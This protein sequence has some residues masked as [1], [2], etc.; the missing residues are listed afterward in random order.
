MKIRC[1]L[2]ALFLA[3]TSAQ[4]ETLTGTPEV[5]DGDTLRMEGETIRLEGID[6]LESR[7]F[8]E[9]AEGLPY[10]CG[11]EATARLKRLIGQDKVKCEGS[12][13]DILG[14][15]IAVCCVL[16]P[17]DKT[18][19]PE[20]TCYQLN[21]QPVKAGHALAQRDFSTRYVSA[22]NEA[23]AAKRGMWAGRFVPPWDWRRGKRLQPLQV[24]ET[25]TLEVVDADALKVLISW[26]D[27]RR[28]AAWAGAAP[29]GARVAATALARSGM[30]DT[31]RVAVLKRLMDM[32][33]TVAELARAADASGSAD[34]WGARPLLDAL[35][36]AGEAAYGANKA[37]VA[38]VNVS[39]ARLDT[40]RSEEERTAIAAEVASAIAAA[41]Q[42]TGEAGEAAYAAAVSAWGAQAGNDA[43]YAAYGDT[44][45]A[46]GQV[47][48]ASRAARQEAACTA[49]AA[50]MAAIVAAGGVVPEGWSLA[51]CYQLAER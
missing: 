35:E 37:N 14:R 38:K 47:M 2:L 15:L 24:A 8:C 44:G 1:L 22:E 3:V 41:A 11:A 12:E 18:G 20:G 48:M 21:D 25:D 50:R 36:A 46:A 33:D 45:N 31:E 10:P 40:A 7:Q 17:E 16:I 30:A 6:A 9:D 28:D 32:A 51:G 13:R 26:A 4:A 42:A 19:G 5:V 34:M 29:P 43:A 27:A 23:K 49:E 39:L